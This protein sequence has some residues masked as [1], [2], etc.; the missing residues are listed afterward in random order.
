MDN[1]CTSAPIGNSSSPQTSCKKASPSQILAKSSILQLLSRKSINFNIHSKPSSDLTSRP[2]SKV[3][4]FWPTFVSI[5]FKKSWSL[6]S[7]DGSSRPSIFNKIS[8]TSSKVSSA[9]AQRRTS[10]PKT[11]K[12]DLRSCSCGASTGQYTHL[13]QSTTQRSSKTNSSSK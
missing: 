12:L 9:N 6:E 11:T 4:P 3:F 13:Y 8:S 10:R 5:T 7:K 2:T 1:F